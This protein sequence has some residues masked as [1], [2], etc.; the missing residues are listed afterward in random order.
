MTTMLRTAVKT[1]ALVNPA[2]SAGIDVSERLGAHVRRS[3]PF[4]S[5]IIIHP[6]AGVQDCSLP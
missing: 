5:L 3:P 1:I 6:E 2:T 4:D